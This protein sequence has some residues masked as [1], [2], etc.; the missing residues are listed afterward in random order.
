[1]KT[2]TKLQNMLA[3]EN[4]ARLR[5]LCDWIRIQCDQQR[6]TWEALSA[7]SG[8][9]HKDLITLFSIHLKTTPMAFIR[10]CQLAKD[11]KSHHQQNLFVKDP[12][13]KN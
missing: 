11:P 13:S 10:Q 3:A 4:E 6:I 9:S 2:V 7:Q 12:I 1:M 8:F 5:V